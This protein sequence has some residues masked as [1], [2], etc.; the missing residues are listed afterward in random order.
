MWATF[1]GA[2][3]DILEESAITERKSFI[4]SF[5]KEIRVKGP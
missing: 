3:Q 5:V 1:R 4:K 2:G